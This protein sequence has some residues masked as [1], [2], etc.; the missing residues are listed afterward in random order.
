MPSTLLRP[1]AWIYGT[2]AASRMKK[3]GARASVPVICVGN[4]TLGGAGKTPAALAIANLLAQ[5]GEQPF[6]LTRG[7]GG[8]LAGPV[9]VDPAVHSA[10]DVGDEPLLLARQAP[11]V[12]AHDRA[13]GAMLAAA[14]GADVIVMDDGLQNPSLE[15][16]IAIAV[17]DA[18]R[19]IGNGQVFPAGP[20]RAPLPAQLGQVDALLVVGERPQRATDIVGKARGRNI[21]VVQGQLRLDATALKAIGRKKVLAFAGIGDPEKFFSALAAA[22]IEAAIEESFPDHHYYSED[23]A[24]RLIARADERALTLVTTEKD[25]VRLSGKPGLEKLAARA[26][27]VPVHLIFQD[28]A[29]IRDMLGQKRGKK[30]R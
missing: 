13:A 1:A 17:V 9:K 2:V 27:A 12:V 11:T 23:D 30:A 29:A 25:F 14:E 26:K 10:A 20:L 24:H 4:L 18:R 19:G 7:Y 3:K 28:V 16:D 22:D 8:A 15:K 21:P 6:F 5:Q